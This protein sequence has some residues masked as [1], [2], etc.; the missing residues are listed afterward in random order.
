MGFLTKKIFS[1]QDQCFGLDLSDLSVKTF[2]IERDGKKDVIRSF[3]QLD[4]PEGL[5]DDGRILDK[6]KVAILIRS[7]IDKA[8]PKKISTKKVICSLP[9]SK[10]FLRIINIPNVSEEEAGEAIKWEIEASIPL[11]VD[12]VYFDWQFLE[13]TKNRQ[14]VLTVAVARDVVDD[15]IEVLEKAGLMVF[16]LEMESVAS[17]RSLIKT[18]MTSE[19]IFLIVDLGSKRT[20]FTIVEG[21]VPY[22][23]SSAPFSSEGLTDIIAKTFGTT[24]K[25]AEKIK[26]VQ[27]IEHSFDSDSVFVSV[28]PFLE[29]LAVEIEKSID[30]YQNTSKQ[31]T[32]IKKIIVCGGGANLKGLVP[33][34]TTRLCKNV[35]MG[36]PWI[37]FNFGNKLPIVSRDESVRY[38]TAI[39]LAMRGINYGNTD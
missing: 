30:F 14:N 4:I 31:A 22:F 26:I 12:Q 9:E 15:T 36:D 39:G 24:Q 37:N 6:E 29:N 25:E 7:A 5:I 10:V 21:N 20:S 38:A 17:A 19:E 13:S 34:L 16:G 3:S 32:E 18:D 27:G 35:T 2:Q 8:R 11:S 23:T 1:S 28:K 33:Y